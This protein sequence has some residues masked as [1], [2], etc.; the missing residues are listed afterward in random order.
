MSSITLRRITGPHFRKLLAHIAPRV[1]EVVR[2]KRQWLGIRN[3]LTKG[4]QISRPIL[5]GSHV[6][7]TAVRTYSDV[8]I[9]IVVR[10]EEIRWGGSLISSTTLL[11]NIRDELRGRYPATEVRRDSHAVAVKFGGGEHG[12][13]VVPAVFEKPATTGHPIYLIPDGSGDWLSTSPDAQLKALN[14]ADEQCG[15]R[16]KIGIR[17]LKWW[18]FSRIPWIPLDS[19]HLE[20]VLVTFGVPRA[21]SPAKL[22]AGIFTTLLGRG[23]RDILDPV[24]ISGFIPIASTDGHERR[25]ITALESA[26]DHSLRAIDAED[27]G[28]LTEAIRQWNLV[29]NYEFTV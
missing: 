6:K 17:L 20:S 21:A 10:K 25:V 8:D 13:D 5:F 9:L 18:M 24:R 14:T 4:F 11:K 15:G 19:V 12:V 22:L 29:F 7:G 1:D 3:R 27:T 2:A 26:V 28:D 16:I 23:G